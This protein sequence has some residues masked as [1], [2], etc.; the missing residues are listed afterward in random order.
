[1]PSYEYI[2]VPSDVEPAIEKAWLEGIGICAVVAGG[3]DHPASFTAHIEQLYADVV[4]R[5]VTLTDVASA[6]ADKLTVS[7]DVTGVRTMAYPSKLLFVAGVQLTVVV[8]ASVIA[9]ASAAV[10]LRGRL[11]GLIVRYVAIGLVSPFIFVAT[12]WK[13]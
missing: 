3:C 9:V 7:P 13:V 1:M 6:T 2:I 5:P 4:V 11:S 8:P 10:G 12:N